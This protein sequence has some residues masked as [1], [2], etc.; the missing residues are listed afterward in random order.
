MK[1]LA[2]ATI[3]LATASLGGCGLFMPP[4]VQNNAGITQV[5]ATF[6]ENGRP[7][8]IKLIDGKQRASSSFSINPKTG[9]ISYA[10]TDVEAF[11][12]H[13]IRAEVDKAVAETQAAVV[14]QILDTIR[15]V[16]PVVP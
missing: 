3:L 4:T 1:H 16:A 5:D 8:T 9:E 14:K 6:F 13:A 10:A 2:L 11:Q 15:G 7:Q 12:A